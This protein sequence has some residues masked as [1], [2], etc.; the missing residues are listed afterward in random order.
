MRSEGREGPDPLRPPGPAESDGHDRQDARPGPLTVPQTQAPADLPLALAPTVSE[1][2][3]GSSSGRAAHGRTLQAA[4]KPALL[5]PRPAAGG[6]RGR[7]AGIR[8]NG[9]GRARS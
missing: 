4:S 3:P 5:P 6:N 1:A 2:A 8:G 9:P 7:E